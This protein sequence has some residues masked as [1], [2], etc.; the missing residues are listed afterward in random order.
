ML[1]CPLEW[2]SLPAWSYSD[3]SDGWVISDFPIT[4]NLPESSRRIQCPFH[5][6]IAPITSI[7][8]VSTSSSPEPWTHPSYHSICLVL[9]QKS[10]PSGNPLIRGNLGCLITLSS[11][12]SSVAQG[13][14]YSRHLIKHKWINRL[15]FS[16]PFTACAHVSNIF[17]PLLYFSLIT[18][19]YFSDYILSV[20]QFCDKVSPMK[21]M[22]PHRI[23][24]SWFPSFSCVMW[25]V[26]HSVTQWSKSLS[27]TYVNSK[28]QML[29]DKFL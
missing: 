8:L 16:S 20:T 13:V 17:L 9:V 24:P 29:L 27:Y 7:I 4:P 28:C 15:N 14:A 22:T 12:S 6:P 26:L 19:I 21:A 23:L 3:L 18:Y 10:H 5:D 1:D 25:W 11:L 2:S